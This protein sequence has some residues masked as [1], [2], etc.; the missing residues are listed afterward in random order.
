VKDGKPTYD[1]NYLGLKRFKVSSDKAIPAGESTVKF[2]F[3]Y[4]GGGAGRRRR[5]WPEHWDAISAA[6]PRL[7]RLTARSPRSGSI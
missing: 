3:A 7:S 2:A 4:D 1:Y 6:A 5:R